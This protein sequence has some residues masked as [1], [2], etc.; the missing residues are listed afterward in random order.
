MIPA[1]AAAAATLRTAE[2]LDSCR[3]ALIHPGLRRFCMKTHF[4]RRALLPAV[5]IGG[6]QLPA[7]AQAFTQVTTG[8]IV[9]D[10]EWCYGCG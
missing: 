1:G 10:G 6:V 9:N 7:H 2:V 3:N 4:L 8:P 5:L